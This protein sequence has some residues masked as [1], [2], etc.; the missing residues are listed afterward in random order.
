VPFPC[1]L[2]SIRKAKIQGGAKVKNIIFMIGD[3]MGVPA[4][5]VGMSV[6]V[7]TADHE[8]GGVTIVNGNMK[9]HTVKLNF[10]SKGHTA[11]MVPVFAFGPGAENFSGI[12]DNTSFL[13]KFL[14]CY[15]FI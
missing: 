10:S 14:S 8:T 7:V 15:K 1:I 3:G 2:G 6:A 12:F 13:G 5:Y 11:V 9:A 4:L